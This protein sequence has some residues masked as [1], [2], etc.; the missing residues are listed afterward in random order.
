[1]RAKSSYIADTYETHIDSIDC[2][3]GIEIEPTRKHPHFH[4]LLTMNHWSYLQID[5][6]K[7][8]VFLEQMFRGR[9]PMGF[10]WGDTLRLVD[11]SGRDFYT[12][13]ENPY[14]DIRLYP[15]DNWNDII[16]A[17]VRKN[18]SPG[19]FEAIGTRAGVE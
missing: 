11:S 16:S 9:D 8:N 4:I 7:M 15:Q 1:M 13:A 14:V 17:Y 19:I 10:G 3:G 12:D 2:D 18:S 5:Y 6:Y